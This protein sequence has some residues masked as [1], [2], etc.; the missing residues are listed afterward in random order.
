MTN[1]PAPRTQLSGQFFD[2]ARLAWQA[3]WFDKQ[4]WAQTEV[5]SKARDYSNFIIVA[6]Y[7]AFFGLWAGMAKDLPP[8]VRLAI[9]GLMTVSIC[10]FIGWELVSMHQRMRSGAR[11]AQTLTESRYPVDFDERWDR[12]LAQNSRGDL[13]LMG[14]WPWIYYPTCVTGLVAGLALAA[15]AFWG[16][17]K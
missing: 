3:R 4:V 12:A 14:I 11:L 9:G 15:A 5:L 10:G 1:D 2:D 17:V 13:R 6:G 7:A 16:V 8:S